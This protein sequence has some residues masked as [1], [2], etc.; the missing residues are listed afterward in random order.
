MHNKI[1][2]LH[3]DMSCGEQRY[4]ASFKDSNGQKQEIEVSCEVY[5]ALDRCRL[6]E[7]RQKNISDRYLEHFDLFENQLAARMLVQPQTVEVV[8]E[9][10]ADMQAALAT[11]TKAQQR[12]FSLYYMHGL[13]YE[14]IAKAENLSKQGVAQSIGRAIEKIK[15]FFSEGG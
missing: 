11:L 13:S 14:E 5:L 6:D 12:R 9:Q 2:H 1:Y 8:V 15:K 7:K 10:A 4:Y 3:T